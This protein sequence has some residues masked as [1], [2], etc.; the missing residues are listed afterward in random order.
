MSDPFIHIPTEYP[1]PHS[2]GHE[3]DVVGCFL[4]NPNTFDDFPHI[5]EKHFHLP[6]TNTAFKFALA[7]RENKAFD[8]TDLLSILEEVNAA[9]LM[10][11]LGGVSNLS[12]MLNRASFPQH[13]SHHIEKLNGY[14]A[15]RLA[16]EAGKELVRSAFEDEI[17]DMIEC[18]S[19]PITAIHDAL[20]A[21][22]PPISTKSIIAE[23]F[24]A[25]KARLDGKQSPMGIETITEIDQY[26]R[27]VHPGRVIIIGAY[28]GGG[29]S[30]LGSQMLLD[31][32]LTGHACL[33]INYEMRERD[34]MDR[35]LIQ[36]SRVPSQAFMDPKTYARENDCHETNTGFLRS[37]TTAKDRLLAAPIR[38]VRPSNR[39]LRTLL[40]V[41]RKGV[42]EMAVKVVVIDYLQ[43]IRCKAGSPE[44]EI[45]EISHAIQEIAQELG[46]SIILLS[47]LNER[48]DTK[49]G[50]V[51]VEDCDAYLVIEQERDKQAENFGQHY[52]I[53]LAKDRHN[54]HSG[55]SIPLIFDPNLVRFVHGFV[56]RKKK[57]TVQKKAGYQQ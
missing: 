35:K 41:I 10:D 46:I 9:G 21:T 45:S 34:S 42:R 12:D 29:K 39:Q 48:G 18:A 50:V 11:R 4:N 55:K 25:Y 24:E 6:D 22:R 5:T 17:E 43:L 28:S 53:L 8:S 37:L 51:A 7:Q 27:G 13:L 49:H 56:D 20:T 2:P 40:A 57:S 30:V 54:G 32:S 16:I 38:I 44:A 52:G 31:V 23:S 1:I 26:L 15:K 19:G 3:R 14:L 47:Q 36:V 33:E